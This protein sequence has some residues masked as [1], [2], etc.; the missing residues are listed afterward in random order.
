MSRIHE[1]LKKAEQERTAVQGG[2]FQPASASP[3]AAELPMPAAGGPSQNGD[4]VV[5]GSGNVPAAAAMS[6]PTDSFSLEALLTRC[7]TRSW[8]PD[9]KTMLFFDGRESS[10]GLEEF[11]TLRSRLYQM[12]DKTPLK[13]ILVVSALPNEGRS[14][15]AANLAQVLA[16]QHGRRV[17][18]IDADLRRPRLHV[19]LGTTST[20]GLTNYLQGASDEFSIMQR[21][22]ME[23]LFFVPS[24]QECSNPSELVANGQLEVLL[25]RVEALFD[26]IIVDSPPAALVS[27]ASV[28]GTACDGVLMVVRSNCTPADMGQR[29]LQEFPDNALIGV[30]LNGA[31]SAV[32]PYARYRS[33]QNLNDVTGGKV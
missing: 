4:T 13:K 10:R 17:L 11:R 31:N 18:L 22:P 12:R 23:N 28:L 15:T 7:T 9:Q 16:Q 32:A 26:W 5:P 19:M 2:E 24:G 30:V 29:A 1:A 33:D 20:P 8:V 21:G 14:F 27:D 3:A 25:Q 6:S